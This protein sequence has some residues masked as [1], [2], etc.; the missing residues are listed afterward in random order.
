MP[1]ISVITPTHN[2]AQYLRQAL[3]S[4]LGQSFQDFEHIIV[5]DGSTDETPRIIEEYAR[6]DARIR[7]V[8]R[9]KASGGPTIPKN[10]ALSLASG[11]YVCFLDQDDYY[12]PDKFRILNDGLDAHPNW[13]A[14]F[15]DLQLVEEDGTPHEGTYLSNADFLARSSGFLRPT[16][17]DDWHDCGDA[18][19]VF[20]SL[21]YAAIHTDSVMLARERLLNDPVSFRAQYRGSDDTDLWLRVGAQGSMGYFNRSL[22]YYRQHG[23]NLSKNL[24]AMTRNAV[25]LHEANYLLARHKLSEEERARYRRKIASYQNTVAYLLNKAGEYKEARALLA[26]AARNGEPLQ[27]GRGLLSSFIREY[28]PGYAGRRIES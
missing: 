10:I 27:A 7:T 4:V 22:A 17:A 25:E 5:D 8:W 21:N 28:L 26:D 15:H 23:S 19:Y 16:G 12:H 18:F 11:P 14:A 3:D 9:E 1:K 24:L 13:V 20:M 2:G 6:R